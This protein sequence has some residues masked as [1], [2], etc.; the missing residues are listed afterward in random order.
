MPAK[1]CT[2]YKWP[3]KDDWAGST[4]APAVRSIIYLG[5]DVHKEST[6]IAELPATQRGPRG[7]IVLH[8]ALQEWGIACEV[9]A[10]S[11]IPRRPGVQRKHDTR[12]AANLARLQSGRRARCRAD[13]ERGRGTEARPRY[14]WITSCR[15]NMPTNCSIFFAR[16]SAL[17]TVWIRN[18]MAYRFALFRVAKN[19][20]AFG[21]ASSAR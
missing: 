4:A 18:R 17:L 6:T 15:F 12:V 1:S 19:A 10:P 5:M 20:F 3:G 13:P 8:R 21:C 14:E 7:S 9:I 16:V 11:L 2:T